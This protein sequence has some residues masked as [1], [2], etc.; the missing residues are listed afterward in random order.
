MAIEFTTELPDEDE[1]VLGNGVKDEVHVDREEAVS[2]NGDIRYQIRRTEDDT[3]DWEDADS[4]QQFI[5]EYDTI[6]FEFVGL[7]D[8]EEYEVRGRTETEYVTGSWIDPVAIIT[9]FPGA[10]DLEA[11]AEQPTRVRLTW[12]DNADNEA[13]QYVWQRDLSAEGSAGDWENRGDAGPGAEEFT[14]YV[15]PGREYEWYIEPYTQFTSAESETTTLTTPEASNAAAPERGWYVEVEHP[16]TGYVHTPGVV[17]TPSRNPQVNNVPELR[18]PVRKADKWLDPQMEDAAVRVWKDGTRQPVDEIA[19]IVP[20]EDAFELRCEGG[21][22][23]DQRVT[24]EY[25][26]EE[27][28]VAAEDLITEH[29]SYE[30]DFDAPQTDTEEDVL[31]REVDGSE[32]EENT[33]TSVADDDP[34]YFDDG[35]HQSAVGY[36]AIADDDNTVR[37][38]RNIDQDLDTWIGQDIYYFDDVEVNNVASGIEATFTVNHRIPADDVRLGV[39][40]NTPDGEDLNEAHH[41]FEFIVDGDSFEQIGA[42][43]LHNDREDPGWF[44]AWGSDGLGEDVGP[45]EVTVEVKFHEHSDESEP[46]TGFDAMLLTDD[47]FDVE[48]S[49]EVVDNVLQG[50]DLYL[51]QEDVLFE[52]NDAA[53]AVTG[54]SADVDLAGTS[55]EQALRL[56]N[57]GG[58]SFGI[59]AENTDTIDGV[60]PAVGTTIRLGATLAGYEDGVHQSHDGVDSGGSITGYE[61][62]ADLSDIPVLD[63]ESMDNDLLSVLRGFA[64]KGYQVFEFDHDGD[65]GVI[66][67]TTPR[68]RESDRVPQIAEYEVEKHV[69]DVYEKVVVF[70]AAQDRRRESYTASEDWQGLDHSHVVEASE[71]VYQDDT[72]YVRGD[73][74]RIRYREGEIRLTGDSDMNEDETYS[75]DYR[76]KVRGEAIADGFEE[77]D[78]QQEF[79]EHVPGLTSE[80]TADQMAL[81]LANELSDVRYSGR[82]VIPSDE[83]GWS[84]IE[85]IDLPGIPHGDRDLEVHNVENEVDR[86]ILT[87]GTRR[88]ADDLMRRVRSQITGL[89]ER[90]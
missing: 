90:V 64:E 17:G 4:F 78:V 62:R 12:T 77:E 2:N 28:H 84:V 66:R 67:W 31:I 51:E 11:S 72:T 49:P 83:V 24:V 57:D 45:G 63:D 22:E 74:Y 33:A 69:A 60:F 86:T 70:G 73:D 10:T 40:F 15:V 23:L 55:G 52:D 38:D 71:V 25:D 32:I 43:L 5:G 9:K 82:I 48:D 30:T 87:L 35:V 19:S 37:G 16:E 18:I 39:R 42:D 41:G 21:S 79:V 14:A 88:S 46:R 7:L 61:L 65:D 56:S 81:I 3:D 75:I 50:P 54:G 59:E 58:D 34:V 89:S 26:T 8:G 85:T 27:V 29:T 36:L 80:R 53:Q 44:T 76:H 6:E 47:R 20:T 13:G 1:P 68:T